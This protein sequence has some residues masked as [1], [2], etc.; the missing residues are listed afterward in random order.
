MSGGDGKYERHERETAF[1]KLPLVGYGKEPRAFTLEI[2][3]FLGRPI[4]A[5]STPDAVMS[6]ELRETYP[7]FGF[8][9][10]KRY[11]SALLQEF[12]PCS[13]HRFS[14]RP[15]REAAHGVPSA[16]SPPRQ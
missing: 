8:D 15:V 7:Q 2:L 9:H 5:C 12:G 4:Y 6:G 11:A 1:A 14:F 13:E 10:R 16:A 3:A